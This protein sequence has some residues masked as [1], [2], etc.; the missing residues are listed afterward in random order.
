MKSIS[1]VFN[2]LHFQEPLLGN[3]NSESKGERNKKFIFYYN[4]I[5]L[6]D[7]I[8]HYTLHLIDFFQNQF[9]FKYNRWI[10]W[11][12]K[13]ALLMQ[14][15][16]TVGNEY[17]RRGEIDRNLFFSFFFW[18]SSTRSIS[19]LLVEY[20]RDSLEI[21]WNYSNIHKDYTTKLRWS[22]E[23]YSYLKNFFASFMLD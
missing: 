8:F 23:M 3:V 19:H 17:T 22:F 5:L 2:K 20:Y 15:I 16:F 11:Q 10:E 12:A 4:L 1:R 9:S 6:S 21:T 14:F 7:E 18:L 13:C